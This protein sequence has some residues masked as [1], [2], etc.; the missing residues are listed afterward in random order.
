MRSPRLL[1]FLLAFAAAGSGLA[2]ADGTLMLTGSD[3]AVWL[4]RRNDEQGSFDAALRKADGEWQWVQQSIS[5]SPAAVVADGARLHVLF[6]EPSEHLI[7]HQETGDRTAALDPIDPLWP[8]GAAPVSLCQAGG[9]ATSGPR[10]ILALVLRPAGGA[11]TRPAA[12]V[13]ALTAP[14]TSLARPPAS[15]PAE[16]YDLGVFSRPGVKWGHV[17]DLPGLSLAPGARAFLAAT[18]RFIYV[19]VSDAAGRDRRLERWDGRAWSNV[20][21]PGAPA[22][23]PP[24]AMLTVH[25]RLLV[26]LERPAG[27]RREVVIGS[28][29]EDA[30]TFTWQPMVQGEGVLTWPRDGL[31]RVGRLGDQLAMAWRE[32]EVIRSGTCLP[33]T[34]MLT[35]AGDIEVFDQPPAGQGQAV[36]EKFMWGVLLAVFI[37]MLLLRPRG[38]MEPFAL[39][40]TVRRGNL[41]KRLLAA[42]IDLLPISLLVTAVYRMM[43]GAMSDEEAARLFERITRGGQNVDLPVELALASISML[44][45]YVLY[46]TVMEARGGATVGKKLMKLRVVGHGGR[47]PDLRQ[48]FL[49]NLLKI[50]ELVSLGSFLAFLVPLVPIFTRH[51]QRFGDLLARTAVVD[52]ESLAQP[53]PGS[54][55]SPASGDDPGDPRDGRA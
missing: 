10:G 37:P 41:L 48:C 11:A 16:R 3:Q 36:L 26:L 2:Q 46:G 19:L 52:A 18:E 29:D 12:T 28:L 27:D 55:D 49:R 40:E 38:A 54:D 34:G 43:P 51:H 1:R 7:I 5:G 39:P 32:G 21:L 42:L 33:Q 20:P 31:P 6:A 15:A 13:P 8:A 24:I 45:V 9:P 25:G 35:L 44:V 53:P 23:S 30:G 47:P 4:V 14:T 17:T 22:D 50:I